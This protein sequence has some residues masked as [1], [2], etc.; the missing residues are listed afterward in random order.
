MKEA[1]VW[2]TWRELPGVVF[3]RPFLRK[4]LGMAFTVGALL[5][6]INHTDTVLAG[7]ATSATWLKGL[8]TC[9]VPFC[10]ANWGILVAQRRR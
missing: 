5:F 6:A 1:P 3:Y 10:V 9:I 8:G 4:S 7:R 2:R